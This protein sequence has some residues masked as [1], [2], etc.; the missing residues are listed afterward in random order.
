ML[1]AA[2]EAPIDEDGRPGELNSVLLGLRVVKVGLDEVEVVAEGLDGQVFNFITV[3]VRH[4][5]LLHW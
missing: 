2:C 5:V 3:V 1:V 4:H